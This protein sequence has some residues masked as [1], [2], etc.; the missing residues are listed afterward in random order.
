MFREYLN[1]YRG[2]ITDNNPNNGICFDGVVNQ[3]RYLSRKK[4]L[5]FLLK[6][7]NG[8]DNNGEKNYI[9]SDWEYM[10]W[11]HKQALQKEPLYRSVYRNIAMWS[12]MFN[13]YTDEK[14]NPEMLELIDEN[15]L[16]IDEKLCNSLLDISIINLKKSWGTEFT[17]WNEMNKYLNNKQRREIVHHQ[18]KVLKPTLVLCG[19][20]FDFVKKIFDNDVAESTK[21]G[22]RFFEKEAT[23]F[24]SCYH[25][26]RPG[27]SRE[28]SFKH[29]DSIFKTFLADKI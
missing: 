17:D 21:D 10:E 4:R 29:A 8:N 15:G 16:I 24:V 18:I 12:R 23:V 2:V 22:I 7:T 27:W 11:V 25:P 20:T 19:G 1:E 28:S 14:R 9:L 26:S 6:E 13:I 3:E 5:M